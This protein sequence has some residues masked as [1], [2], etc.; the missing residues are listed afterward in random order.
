MSRKSG[1][2]VTRCLAQALVIGG[3]AG[4]YIGLYLGV[5]A[6]VS[7]P[8]TG[9]TLIR[10]Y[11]KDLFQLL[12]IPALAS[13]CLG[14]GLALAAWLPACLAE[15]KREGAGLALMAFVL[16]SWSVVAPTWSSM[17][18]A[19]QS[20]WPLLQKPVIIFNLLSALFVS[21]LV[22]AALAAVIVALQRRGWLGRA[23]MILAFFWTTGT[24]L[25]LAWAVR[26]LLSAG[27][28]AGYLAVGLLVVAFLWVALLP[29]FRGKTG[30]R[31]TTVYGVVV[32]VLHLVAGLTVATA[33]PKV[34]ETEVLPAAAGSGDRRPNIVLLTVDTLRADRLSCYGAERAVTPSLDRLSREAVLF[35]RMTSNAPWT[36][37]AMS[38]LFTGRLP[39]ALGMGGGPT[40]LPVS[41]P[42]L[43]TVLADHGYLTRAFATNTWLKRDFGFDRGFH[44]YTHLE[45]GGVAGYQLKRMFW[46]RL[47]PGNEQKTESKDHFR[48]DRVT[49]RALEW[50]ARVPVE[51]QPFFL[52][53]HYMD[54]HEPYSPKPTPAVGPYRGRYVD[55][56]GLVRTIM[57]G[58]LLEP[59][60]LE[61]LRLLYDEE[62]LA[63]DRQLGRLMAL[64]RARGLLER[65]VVVVTSDHGE[66]FLE[67]GRM[68]HGQSLYDELL[69]V[70]LLIRL[71]H[72]QAALAPW[73]TGMQL[74]DLP[75]TLISLAGS[76]VPPGIQGR[77][78]A[79]LFDD[80]PGSL[81]GDAG[82]GPLAVL[83][84]G[85]QDAVNWKSLEKGDFK[86]IL[87]RSSGRSRLF[88]ADPLDGGEIDTGADADLSTL[89]AELLHRI[90]QIDRESRE[91]AAETAE[92]GPLD[93]SRMSPEVRRQLR[94]LG[95]L[96]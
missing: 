4:L 63:F 95:Y 36:L 25:T 15:R 64:L 32:L 65:S 37:P 71:P 88:H 39:S 17:L 80:I 2:V 3:L 91:L 92:T 50:L 60:D 72:G 11:V 31:R 83:S 89:S 61:R 33:L 9:I 48:A 57:S 1:N 94:S 19:G 59:A 90:H 93:P 66:E 16:G 23:A 28:W 13:A 85:T 5:E 96:D 49:D 79:V 58:D 26:P 43:T 34:P 62:I 35:Q 40:R 30:L 46:Y 86:I 68:G 45:E 70:P 7:Q 44:G 27:L 24:L 51:G 10:F 12:Y 20:P 21:L 6:L 42:T 87:D 8:A 76:K 38:A 81:S 18:P 73:D 78:M 55:S 82:L 22:G 77:D 53:L 29:F 67:H 54:P 75:P 56:S 14:I 52:W 74:I 84:E 41:V 69:R 47:L